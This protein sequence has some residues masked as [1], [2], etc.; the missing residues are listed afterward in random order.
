MKP[1]ERRAA[2]ASY[3]RYVIGYALFILFRCYLMYVRPHPIR[4]STVIAMIGF[5]L[6]VLLLMFLTYLRIEYGLLIIGILVIELIARDT[7]IRALFFLEGTLA[8]VLG[9]LAFRKKE[10]P[11]R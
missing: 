11:A 5:V 6:V 10:M 2:A 1:T 3:R 7:G 8:V 4:T 9:I